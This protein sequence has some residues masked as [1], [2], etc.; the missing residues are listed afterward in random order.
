MLS[1]ASV[2]KI[3]LR[4]CGEI[5]MYCARPIPI[6]PDPQPCKP[7]S[8]PVGAPYHVA[9]NPTRPLRSLRLCGQ[10]ISLRRP[11]GTPPPVYILYLYGHP[12]RGQNEGIFPAFVDQSRA[13]ASNHRD[14]VIHKF[15]SFADRSIMKPCEHNCRP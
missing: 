12:K 10:K 4:L 11:G 6:P 13:N 2:V 15:M 5:K 3:P 1:V 7:M 9:R 8:E 14:Q